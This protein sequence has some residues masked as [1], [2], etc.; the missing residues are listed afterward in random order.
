MVPDYNKCAAK[1]WHRVLLNNKGNRLK[2][3]LH[4]IFI[5]IKVL[6]QTRLLAASC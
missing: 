5:R 2:V 4:K 3:I 1:L 6:M